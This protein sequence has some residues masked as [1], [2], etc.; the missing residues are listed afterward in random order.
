[1]ATNQTPTNKHPIREKK[2][3]LPREYYRGEVKTSFTACIIER[4]TPFTSPVIVNAFVKL[5]EFAVLKN[6]C[7][8]IYSFMPD[9]AHIIIIGT[10][11]D[12]DTYQAMVDFKQQTGFWFKSH[13]PQYH[14]QKD[15]HDHIIRESE[16][17]EEHVLYVVHNAVR[18]GLVDDWTDYPFTGSIGLDLEEFIAN[19]IRVRTY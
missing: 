1:M 3:R 16:D 12:S 11:P 17:F 7:I 15:F 6:A 4:K 2:H 8:A 18:K 14:W 13:R 5:L 10:Q 19:S 9:H